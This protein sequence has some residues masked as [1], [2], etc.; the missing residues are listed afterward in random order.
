[1]ASN[2]P[3]TLNPLTDSTAGVRRWSNPGLCWV[4][5]SVVPLLLAPVWFQWGAIDELSTVRGIPGLVL[6][7]LVLTCGWTD[8]IYRRIPNW[9]TYPAMLWSLTLNTAASITFWLEMNR[10]DEIA[11]NA[12]LPPGWDGWLTGTVGLGSSLAGFIACSTVM[13]LPFKLSRSGAGDVKLAAAIGATIGFR[14]GMLVIAATYLVA[15]LYVLLYA[16][17]TAGLI[18]TVCSVARW[19]GAILL[20]G[21][22]LPPTP[23]QKKLLDRKVP[24]GPFFAIGAAIILTRLLERLEASALGAT[25]GM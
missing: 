9:A 13:L 14:D 8:L 10:G 20:L 1:M 3:P 19:C 16:I 23:E 6:V 12:P 24:L 7:C 18:E 2:T 22:I 5:A 11:L 21:L 15:G 4:L 17:W 25:L